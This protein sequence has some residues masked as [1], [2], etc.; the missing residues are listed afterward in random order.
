MD[1]QLKAALI[2]GGAILI[3]MWS[4]FTLISRASARVLCRSNDAI[5][6]QR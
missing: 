2:L 1:S 4:Y 3:G 5:A 6:T